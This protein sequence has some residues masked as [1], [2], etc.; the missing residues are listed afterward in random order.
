MRAHWLLR[1]SNLSDFIQYK[2]QARS[3]QVLMIKPFNLLKVFQVNTSNLDN[4]SAAAIKMIFPW[5]TTAKFEGQ[6]N[7]D[8]QTSMNFN[9]TERPV[10]CFEYSNKSQ[11]PEY[12]KIQERP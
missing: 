2:K 12:S 10:D 8:D 1:Y 9:A 6:K 5:T 4:P 3:T 7:S 11:H